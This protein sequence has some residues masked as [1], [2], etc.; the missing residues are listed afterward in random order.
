VSEAFRDPALDV[1]LLAAH[2]LELEPFSPLLGAERRGVLHGFRVAARD[3][4]VGMPLAGV[5]S[6][7]CLRREPPRCAVLVGSYGIYP[8]RGVFQAGSLLVPSRIAA[9][10]SAVQV[11]QAAFPAIMTTEIE[12]DSALSQGLCAAGA[13]ALRGPVA[14]TLG[15]T[16]DDAL[17]LRLGEQSGCGAENLE[18]LSVALACRAAG[19][20]FGAVLACTNRV[21][22]SGRSQWAQ[23]CRGAAIASARCI[24]AWLAAG[25]PGMP[26]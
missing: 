8:G 19:V 12:P 24:E 18:G 10:D 6:L 26:G 1:L 13:G 20:P 4:G 15:I 16:T 17:A 11:G 23:H 5:G 2:P 21:G 22:S 9:V 14:T 7:G 25:A 3:V